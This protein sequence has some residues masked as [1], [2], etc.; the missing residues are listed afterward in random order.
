LRV[1]YTSFRVAGVEFQKGGLSPWPPRDVVKLVVV[2]AGDFHCNALA[3][4]I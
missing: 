3:G 1:V 4:R 2:Q